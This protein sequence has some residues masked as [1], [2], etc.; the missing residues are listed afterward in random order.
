MASL[1]PTLMR[2]APDLSQTF[3]R[4]P[5]ETLGG[6]VVA[7]RVLDKCRATLAGTDGGY[8]FN[9]PLDRIFFEFT[10]IDAE[11]FREFVA[12]GASDEQVGEWLT[13]HAT[14]RERIEVIR[15]NNRMREMRISELDDPLQR[16]LEDYIPTILKPGKVVYVWFDV[17]DIEEGR[18]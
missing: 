11:A 7:A 2:L 5:R 3:P 12:T 15:W 4:S 1:N 17:Y 14:P 9:C 16:L 6:F 13:A 18:L 8:I 10:G